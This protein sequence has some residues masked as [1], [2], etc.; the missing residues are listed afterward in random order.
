EEQDPAPGG[1]VPADAAEREQE[2]DGDSG[3]E[4]RGPDEIPD[5]E[6]QVE[7]PPDLAIG[8]ELLVR[9]VGRI[10]GPRVEEG[11]AGRRQV[12][13]GPEAEPEDGDDHED[14]EDRGDARTGREPPEER[15]H[16]PH[17]AGQRR[18]SQVTS[19]R[20]TRTRL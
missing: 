13:G 14:G 2:E 4:H 3:P 10:L 5:Q 1:A 8:G 18:S 12:G 9:L 7:P 11:Y 19:V 6:E 17:H 20:A 16:A 15:H